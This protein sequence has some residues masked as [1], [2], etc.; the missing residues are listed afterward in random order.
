MDFHA[1]V[2]F[3][4]KDDSYRA[5]KISPY[6]NAWKWESRFVEE[7]KSRGRAF[8]KGFDRQSKAS[9]IPFQPMNLIGF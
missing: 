4:P 9:T 5:Q 3:K 1:I 6:L 8:Q 2:V 7:R